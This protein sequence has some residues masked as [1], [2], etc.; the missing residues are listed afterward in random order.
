M[1]V[2]FPLM[3]AASQW[4]DTQPNKRVHG[5]IPDTGSLTS[6]LP[7]A[8]SMLPAMVVCRN[9]RKSLY[10][11]LCLVCVLHVCVQACSVKM[12]FHVGSSRLKLR[13]VHVALGGEFKIFRFRS[14]AKVCSGHQNIDAKIFHDTPAQECPFSYPPDLLIAKNGWKKRIC[15]RNN[16][17]NQPD[18][19]NARH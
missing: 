7:K 2:Y 9:G 12:P 17:E 15:F 19:R 13:Q 10:V 11:A 6:E 8:Y 18:D 1:Q 3:P 14:Q 5:Y 16:N 4:R